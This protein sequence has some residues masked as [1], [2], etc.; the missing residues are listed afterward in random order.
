[1]QAIFL[2]LLICQPSDTKADVFQHE[3]P[4]RFSRAF[5]QSLPTLKTHLSELTKQGRYDEIAD[6]LK[7]RSADWSKDRAEQ[8]VGLGQLLHVLAITDVLPESKG[9]VSGRIDQRLREICRPHVTS[10]I[11]PDLSIPADPEVL[12]AQVKTVRDFVFFSTRDELEN[13][14]QSAEQRREMLQRTS[15]VWGRL[16]RTCLVHK[17]TYPEEKLAELFSGESKLEVPPMPKIPR[18]GLFSGGAPE[19][20]QDPQARKQY[21]AYLKSVQEVRDRFQAAKTVSQLRT[22][23]LKWVRQKF[24]YLYGEDRKTWDE[25]RQV[26]TD[27]IQDPDVAQ[28]VIKDFT[29]RKEPGL[30]P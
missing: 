11:E 5:G 12:S 26:V 18:L 30:W 25:L 24:Q 23:E 22:I 21:E 10:V 17:E 6:E 8:I 20:I 1:M 2:M 3:S 29:R 13:F 28:L 4:Y 7:R 14:K 16:V 19:S 15:R 27:T 9:S